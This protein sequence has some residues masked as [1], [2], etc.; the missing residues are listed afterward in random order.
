[1]K[2]NQPAAHRRQAIPQVIMLSNMRQFM[3]QNISQLI[4]IEMGN[5]FRGQQNVTPQPVTGGGRTQLRY[6][7]EF[8]VSNTP[9]ETKPSKK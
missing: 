4:A 2:E 9:L 5:Q 1:M 3:P 8:T 6:Q 7:T